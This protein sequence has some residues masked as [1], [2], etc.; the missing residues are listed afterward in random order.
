MYN[1]LVYLYTKNVNCKKKITSFRPVCILAEVLLLHLIIFNKNAIEYWCN[2]FLSHSKKEGL[3]KH[4]PW[5]GSS[6]CESLA[7]ANWQK[8]KQSAVNTFLL[9]KVLSCK[10][11]VLWTLLAV[12]QIGFSWKPV[13]HFTSA[14]S[15]I[16]CTS[17]NVVN[18]AD[19]LSG[20]V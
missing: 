9:E 8:R 5:Q 15:N 12:Q 19:L 13:F 11:Q 10:N 18:L 14:L 6:H 7:G 2:L 20:P 17:E 1:N 3:S 16:I 4:F